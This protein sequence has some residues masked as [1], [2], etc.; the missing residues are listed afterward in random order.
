MNN[1]KRIPTWKK[2]KPFQ[3]ESDAKRQSTRLAILCNYTT[4]VEY[5]P[6]EK[7][8][9]LMILEKIESQQINKELSDYST[10]T[11]SC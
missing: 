5:E 10:T 2:F 6:S 8:Y 9:W 11:K 3:R 4:R 1:Y 7:I